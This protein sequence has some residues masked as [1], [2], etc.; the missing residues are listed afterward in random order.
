M[1]AVSK[2][3]RQQKLSFLTGVSRPISI[4]LEICF[5][6]YIRV[7]KKGTLFG[8]NVFSTEEL[9]GDTIFTSPAGDGTAILRGHPS[10]AKV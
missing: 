5:L 1:D 2:Y 7:L 4:P 8:V 3:C 6:H 10:H 9:I